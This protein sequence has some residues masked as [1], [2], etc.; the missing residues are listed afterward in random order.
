MIE[1]IIKVILRSAIGIIVFSTIFSQTTGKISGKVI[2]A[3]T[4]EPIVGANILILNTN[5]GTSSD[6]DGNY[7]LINLNPKT[8]DIMVSVIGY[9]QTTYKGIV[10]SVNRTT[11]L[12]FNIKSTV[13]EG[14][15]V[16]VKAS[17]VNIKK[18]QTGSVKNISSDVLDILPVEDINAVINAMVAAK[19]E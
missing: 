10:V 19:N 14:E 9:K 16:I 2:D 11:N 18:D 6:V 7:Y 8:Y 5:F 3:D 1:N 13:L 17:Q 15:T 12:N 4:N